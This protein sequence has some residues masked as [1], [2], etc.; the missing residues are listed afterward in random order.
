M[1]K[2]RSPDRSQRLGVDAH[3]VAGVVH[4]IEVSGDADA[5]LAAI[6]YEIEQCQARA[7][8]VDVNEATA[9]SERDAARIIAALNDRRLDGHWQIC[10]E[11]RPQEGDASELARI[12]HTDGREIVI[13]RS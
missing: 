7:L 4:I 1:M 10:L 11:G 2:T 8:V 9:I 6:Q 3:R 5:I 13:S 12:W